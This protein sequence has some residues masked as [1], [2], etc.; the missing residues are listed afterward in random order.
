MSDEPLFANFAVFNVQPRFNVVSPKT[1]LRYIAELEG[2]K[3]R[4]IYTPIKSYQI[5]S[6]ALVKIRNFTAHGF[7]GS[8]DQY[9]AIDGLLVA[10]LFAKIAKSTRR[11]YEELKAAKDIK[12]C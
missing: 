7:Y 8:T 4:T 11:Y 9:L 3:T 5:P 2:G 6:D 12:I 1:G 10:W